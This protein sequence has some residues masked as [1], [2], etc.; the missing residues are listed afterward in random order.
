MFALPLALPGGRLGGGFDAPAI[1][2]ARI[3]HDDTAAFRERVSSCSALPAGI[4]PDERIRI[5]LR[6]YFKPDGTLASQPQ[7][8]EASASPK[9]PALMQSAVDALQKCQ[10]YTMLPADKYKEWQTL[11]LGF[12][13]LNFPAR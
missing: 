9:G 12:T 8:I 7:L 3:A 1:D 6:V 5:V 4:A 2:A 10:P 11:D 13:P